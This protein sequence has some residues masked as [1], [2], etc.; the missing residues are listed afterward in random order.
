MVW[1]ELTEDDYCTVCDLFHPNP[2]PPLPNLSWLQGRKCGREGCLRRANSPHRY[3]CESCCRSPE[4][5]L[6]PHLHH[7]RC[8]D[9]EVNQMIPHVKINNDYSGSVFFITFGVKNP[10]SDWLLDWFSRW[11]PKAHY[12]TWHQVQ[13]VYTRKTT[14]RKWG[15]MQAAQTEFLRVHGDLAEENIEKT[16][17]LVEWYFSMGIICFAI[18]IACSAGHHRSPAHAEVSKQRACIRYPNVKMSVFH[19]DGRDAWLPRLYD[20]PSLSIVAQ[21]YDDEPA[22]VGQNINRPT[23]DDFIAF[24]RAYHATLQNPPPF[25]LDLD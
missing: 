3:C 14:L 1:T 12:D 13:N 19:L 20:N 11:L 10:G 6:P 24:Q 16:L 21:A 17:W 25:L 9:A 23:D 8:I 7:R 18:P 5:V 15:H 4:G 2:I 22:H